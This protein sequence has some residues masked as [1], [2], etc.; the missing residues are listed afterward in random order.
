M[1]EMYDPDNAIEKPTIARLL[2]EAE[3]AIEV[4]R[5]HKLDWIDYDKALETGQYWDLSLMSE[6]KHAVERKEFRL[7]LQPKIRLHD[8]V[9]IS[10][11]A[12]LRWQH[13]TRGLITPEYFIPFAEQT[14]CIRM[15][16]HW[17]L[18][19][20]MAFSTQ[21]RIEGRPIQI[22]VNLSAFDM[23]DAALLD[24]LTQVLE[25]QGTN[26]A[27]IRIEITEHSAMSDP[28]AALEVM[29]AIRDLGFSLSIDDFGTG[30]SSL[31]YLQRMPVAEL[32]IDRAFIHNV[33][34][35]TDGFILLKSIIE[36][37]HQLDL[38]IVA[39]GI[40]TK[41][42]WAMLRDLRCDF[43]QGFFAAPAMTIEDFEEWRDNN[44]PFFTEMANSH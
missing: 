8:G 44:T 13:P 39:E 36:L 42:E 31:A 15:I 24:F 23:E 19:Q 12:L 29:R 35:D 22:A 28:A 33:R 43:M 14:G 41:E 4:A 34:P 10:A 27:D 18:E 16:T 7:Y 25:K 40:E 1:I 38:S 6:L 30:Y 5:E 26:P 21:M 17:A 11:E 9:M 3:V 2:R 20:A 32:K 37:G